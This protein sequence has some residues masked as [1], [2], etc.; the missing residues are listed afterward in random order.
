LQAYAPG[1]RPIHV[2]YR[3]DRRPLP[4]LSGFVEHLLAQV[5]TFVP[6][7]AAQ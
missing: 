6:A 4:K 7:S 5:P 2:V 3:Q 1:P